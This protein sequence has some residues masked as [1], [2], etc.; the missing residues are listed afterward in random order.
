[1]LGG[2]EMQV[3]PELQPPSPLQLVA[4]TGAG[5]SAAPVHATAA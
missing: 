5:W 2:T 1:M 3:A 4:Q